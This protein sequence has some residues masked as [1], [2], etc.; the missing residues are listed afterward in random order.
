[1]FKKW[2]GKCIEIF[3]LIWQSWNTVKFILAK[4]R[5]FHQ[6]GLFTNLIWFETEYVGK[7]ED[8]SPS[9]MSMWLFWLTILSRILAHLFILL[10]MI[11][12]WFSSSGCVILLPI[13]GEQCGHVTR[14]PPLIG[15]MVTCGLTACCHRPRPGC[16][17]AS[18][19]APRPAPWRPRT[20]CTW[21]KWLV[22][23]GRFWWER[24]TNS[25]PYVDC[26][27][28]WWSWD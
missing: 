3:N 23:T 15:H 12:F 2:N 25:L 20:P 17:P 26:Y 24:E 14:C 8:V 27:Y 21:R 9:A 5:Q 11:S 22:C 19:P 13:T 4:S 10:S 28:E 7:C 6:L 1:M 18:A 16:S